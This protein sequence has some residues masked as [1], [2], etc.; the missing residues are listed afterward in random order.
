MAVRI[1]KA[2][3]TAFDQASPVCHGL[4]AASYTCREFFELEAN[5]LFTTSWSFVGFAH[6]LAKV[7]DVQPLTVAGK[8]VFLVRSEA[9]KIRAFHNVCR[10]RN[11]KLIDQAGHCDSLITCPYHRW[12]Y[13]FGGQLRLAPY[14]GGGKT[15][16]PDGFDLANHGLY[17]IQCHTFHDWIFVNLDGQAES[18]DVFVEP[19]KRQL[20]GFEPEEFEAVATL[21]FGEVSTNW[22]LL[23]EN[24]I[25]PYHVQYVHKTTTS[26][27]LEDH[28]VVVDEHCL[29]SAI[30][31]TAEQQAG[32]A[33]G[34]LG[35]SSRYLTLFPNF[36]LGLYYPDQ[37]GVHLNRPVSENSTHQSRVI[38]LHRDSDQSR[39]AVEQLRQLWDSVHR[40]DHEMCE[41]LQAGRHSTVAEDGG[42]LSPHWEV[43][44]RRFQ[45]LVAD[46]VRPG[47][48]SKI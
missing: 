12:S 29:G 22:K 8:P 10:H 37:I 4:P 25:E 40:E 5:Q 14:F 41:R 24:F 34:T 43:S 31:L 48:E 30:D 23:M 35:V 20:V 21:E 33:V 45:E 18:F 44:V 13:D 9:D 19:L 39:P 17:E 1:D 11:L 7:G 6:Q 32:A 47:L 36:V 42:V 16:L 3:F 26:Q 28:Y 15:G 2:F 38:Y 27:P 46:A